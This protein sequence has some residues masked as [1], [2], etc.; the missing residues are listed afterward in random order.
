MLP[1]DDRFVNLTCEYWNV[2]EEAHGHID[3][4]GAYNVIALMRQRLVT[5]ANGSQEE[6][7]LRNIFR[8]FDID[9]SGTLSTHELRGL[10][11]NLGVACSEP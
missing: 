8:K 1:N 11:S 2:C 5:L 6:Y 4:R 9:R 3:L 7:H 10:L